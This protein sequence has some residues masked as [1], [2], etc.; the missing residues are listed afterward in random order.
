MVHAQAK[1]W[2]E[3]A[4][5]RAR[6][7]EVDKA[8]RSFQ[9]ELLNGTKLAGVLADPY[10]AVI[11][12]AFGRYEEGRG[13]YVLFQGVVRRDRSHQLRAIESIE[14]VTSLD[15]LDVVL[16][17]DE[18]A[19]AENGWLNGDGLAPSQELLD[20]LKKAFEQDFDPE[21]SLPYLY[22]TT[23]GGVQAEWSLNGWEVSIKIDP[24]GEHAEY[25]AVN[26]ESD[27]SQETILA[28]GDSAGWQ[29]LNENLKS[30]ERQRPEEQS[31]AS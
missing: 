5:L 21:L 16:R 2:T 27:A 30:I 24:T 23:E 12:E 11:L 3:E 13:N 14:H 1:E 8:R 4:T 18:L 20:R 17:L 15:P 28:L 26:I 29:Q 6:I 22:P 25:Q 19:K 31:I 10:R 9:I 7:S